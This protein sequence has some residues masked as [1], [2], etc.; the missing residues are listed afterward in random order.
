MPK[1]L[2]CSRC[3][4][5]LGEINKGRIKSGAVLLCG[6]CNYNLLVLENKLKGATKSDFPNIFKEFKKAGLKI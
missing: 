1:Q 5:N 3:N 4:K 6:A 2:Y